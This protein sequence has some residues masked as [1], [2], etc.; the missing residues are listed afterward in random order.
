MKKVKRAFKFHQNNLNNFRYLISVDNANRF[1]IENFESLEFLLEEAF[2][3]PQAVADTIRD[4]NPCRPPRHG[5]CPSD[6]SGSSDELYFEEPEVEEKKPSAECFFV[7]PSS[8][9]KTR[10]D[11]IE[12]LETTLENLDEKIESIR[13]EKLTLK[14]QICMKKKKLHDAIL[15]V[16]EFE[17]QIEDLEKLM[18]TSLYEF[19]LRIISLEKKLQDN[20][21][22]N[23]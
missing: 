14:Q 2:Q 23:F 4:M 7:G 15:K 16:V 1:L 18:E 22:G 5:K 10:V 6:S 12:K 20:F 17:A 11:S 3:Y 19:Q 13:D 8:L 9:L 21:Q